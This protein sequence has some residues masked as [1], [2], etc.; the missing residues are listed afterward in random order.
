[1][2]ATVLYSIFA[3]WQLYEIHSGA[4]DTHDL[5]VAAGKQADKMKDMSDAA[6][7]IRQAAEGMVAQEQRIANNAQESVAASNRQSNAALDASIAASRNDQ[8]AWLGIWVGHMYPIDGNSKIRTEIDIV[9]TGKTPAIHIK[10]AGSRFIWQQPLLAGPTLEI[11]DG[12]R[13]VSG[14]PVP[15][16]GKMTIS[17]EENI[18]DIGA[19]WSGVKDG[20]KIIYFAGEVRYDDIFG[21]PHRTQFCLYRAHPEDQVLAACTDFHNM[22]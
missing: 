8:R 20:T 5:A 4:K 15:P 7:K 6:E 14:A 10:Q 16:Q 1:M 3:G 13:F 9:N 18:A 12:F 2:I 19:D 11:V 22:N 21:R 17:A